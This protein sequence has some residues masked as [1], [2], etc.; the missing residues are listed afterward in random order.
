M[1]S[2]LNDIY[3][4][5]LHYFFHGEYSYLIDNDEYRPLLFKFIENSFIEIDDI[6]FIDFVM[7]LFNFQFNLSTF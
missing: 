6:K 5:I 4:S 1:N 3:K 2:T 7:Q